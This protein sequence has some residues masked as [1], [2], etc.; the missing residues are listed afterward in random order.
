MEM[1]INAIMEV[2]PHRYPFLL[3]DRIVSCEPNERVSAYKNVTMNE[4]FFQGHFPIKPVMPGVLILEALAQTG[5]ILGYISLDATG[6][7]RL[8]Y[9]VGMDKVKFRRMVEPGDRLDL[10]AEKL[11]LGSRFWKLRCE[12]RVGDALAVECVMN[13]VL[14]PIS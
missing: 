5:A 2:L 12:A 3:V 7:T 11:R 6:A 1:D 4:P 10:T 8:A 13:A 14:E 9:I